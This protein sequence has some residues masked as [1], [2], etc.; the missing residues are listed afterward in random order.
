MI[1]KAYLADSFN[2]KYVICEE[3]DKCITKTQLIK[4]EKLTNNTML[5]V[6]YAGSVNSDASYYA[7]INDMDSFFNSFPML[8]M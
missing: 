7:A 1:N 3:E 5:V 4:P 6:D 8:N 2:D